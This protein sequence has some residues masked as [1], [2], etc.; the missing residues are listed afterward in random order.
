[1]DIQPGRFGW[2]AKYLIPLDGGAGRACRGDTETDNDDGVSEARSDDAGL[3]VFYE[4]RVNPI[5]QPKSVVAGSIKMWPEQQTS[6]AAF[7]WSRV[8]NLQ[9]GLVLKSWMLTWFLQ[10]LAEM[11]V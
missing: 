11:A 7:H 6:R 9:A 5:L 8:A 1:M 3:G 4:A 2:P 10:G